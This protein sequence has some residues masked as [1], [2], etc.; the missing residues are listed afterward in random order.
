M[1]GETTL[2]RCEKILCA[3]GNILKKCIIPNRFF[4]RLLLLLLCFLCLSYSAGIAAIFPFK[5][6]C[7]YYIIYINI[8]VYRL[9]RSYII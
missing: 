7:K 3:R 2:T 1:L 4:F 8:S 6:C 5:K 9:N